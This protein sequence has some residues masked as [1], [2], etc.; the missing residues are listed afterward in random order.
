[1]DGAA[2]YQ[3]LQA[4]YGPGVP[5]MIFVTR[6]AHSLDYAGF[7]GVAGILVLA[8]PFTVDDLQKAVG[9]ALGPEGPVA[10]GYFLSLIAAL[11]FAAISGGIVVILCAVLACSAPFA[12]TSA[13]SFPSMTA[14]HPGMRSPQFRTFAM[15]AILLS[16]SVVSSHLRLE[17]CARVVGLSIAGE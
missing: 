1:M 2:F 12:I 10:V 9:Q 5:R 4:K 14:L 8:K 15:V 11:T 13:S 16:G 17:V 7:L 3:A 6:Q